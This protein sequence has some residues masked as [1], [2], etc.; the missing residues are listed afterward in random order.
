MSSFIHSF[1]FSL[2]RLI[3]AAARQW[4]DSGFKQKTE[5]ARGD[6]FLFFLLFIYMAPQPSVPWVQVE[7]RRSWLILFFKFEGQEPV[8]LFFLIYKDNCRRVK[9]EGLLSRVFH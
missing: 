9:R 4:L 7:G 6:G 2:G 8:P 1:H 5:G 3:D